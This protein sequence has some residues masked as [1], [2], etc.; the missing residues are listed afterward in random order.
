MTIGSIKD[1]EEAVAQFER[2]LPTLKQ[3]IEGAKMFTGTEA[4]VSGPKTHAI[5]RPYNRKMTK[6]QKKATAIAGFAGN[7]IHILQNSPNKLTHGDIREAAIAK[8]Y[9]KGLASPRKVPSIMG[10]LKAKG[11]VEGDGISGYSLTSLGRA[12]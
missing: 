1:L 9:L 12:K 6:K 5:K 2:V 7:V 4:N 10:Y 3:I 8:G 11:L